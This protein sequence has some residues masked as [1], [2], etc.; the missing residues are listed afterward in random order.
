MDIKTTDVGIIMISFEKAREISIAKWTGEV[1]NTS[2][3][4]DLDIDE[5]IQLKSHFNCG[6]CWR[7]GYE[8]YEYKGKCENCEF[9]QVA[10]KCSDEASLYSQWERVS[11]D[12]DCVEEAK[13]LA[14]KILKVIVNLKEKEEIE[15][16]IHQ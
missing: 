2:P 1:N 14:E 4:F 13:E 16:C 5:T 3:I 12:E 11:E 8:S 6:F 15:Q 7:H 10:G 9:A